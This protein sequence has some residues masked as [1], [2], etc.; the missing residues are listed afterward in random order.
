LSEIAEKN[1]IKN[2][3]VGEQEVIQE[4]PVQR[5]ARKMKFSD[6]SS[7]PEQLFQVPELELRPRPIDFILHCNN[8]VSSGKSAEMGS[9]H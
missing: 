1:S 2:A 3:T 8:L 7:F 6:V 9:L 5:T 4:P